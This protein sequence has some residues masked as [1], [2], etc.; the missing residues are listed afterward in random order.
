MIK[1]LSTFFQRSR[2]DFLSEL[3]LWSLGEGVSYI[4]QLNKLKGLSLVRVMPD[5]DFLDPG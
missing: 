2:L 1:K 4:A 3:Y 5:F